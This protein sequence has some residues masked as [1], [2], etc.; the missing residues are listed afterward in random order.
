[1]ATFDERD[2]AVLDE[3]EKRS[4]PGQ[5]NRPLLMAALGLAL[6]LGGYMATSYVPATPR[7]SEQER[8]LAEFRQRAAGVRRTAGTWN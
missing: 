2:D 8:R 4:T 5:W 6:M 3:E 7:Q 1:M